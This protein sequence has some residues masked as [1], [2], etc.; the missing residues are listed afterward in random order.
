MAEGQEQFGEYNGLLFVS[1]PFLSTR[2][3]RRISHSVR[4]ATSRAP[5]P[6][7]VTRRRGG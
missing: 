4:P 1:S 2:L 5:G 7:F 6:T 3:T